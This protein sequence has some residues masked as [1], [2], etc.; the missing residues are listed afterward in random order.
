MNTPRADAGNGPVDAIELTD[1]K[2][3]RNVVLVS[4]DSLRADHCGFMGCEWDT[5]PSIDRLAENSIVF[6]N[7][8]TPGPRTPSSMPVAFTG[9]FNR[10][11]AFSWGEWDHRYARIS[12]H[13][14]RHQTIAERLRAVGYTTVGVTVN[15]WTH[16]TD[17]DIGFD[18][19][20]EITGDAVTA[21]GRLNAP[22]L[23][24]V[25]SILTRTRNAKNNQWRLTKDWLVQWTHYYETILEALEDITEPYF[26][27]T[28]ILDPHQPYLAPRRYRQET[29]FP[30]MYYANFREMTGN[31]SEGDLSPFLQTR[32][33]RSYR[34]AIRSTDGFIERLLGDLEG[35]PAVIIHS[36]HGD[37]LGEHGNWGHPSELYEENLH[38]PLLVY[39]GKRVGRVS[40]P[41]SLQSLPDLTLMIATHE[42]YAP[43]DITEPYVL[44]ATEG[45]EKRALRGRRWKLITDGETEAVF[46]LCND[47]T[48][49]ID[50]SADYPDI[51]ADLRRLLVHKW[52]HASEQVTVTEAA[53]KLG[54]QKVVSGEVRG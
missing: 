41:V 7:A 32:L 38:V 54:Q 33:K 8:I 22:L 12:A 51:T 42:R 49:S 19:F 16:N 44:V 13:L 17:F 20:I 36:D 1:T 48:E 37:A 15:P 45:I 23:T 5:T 6:E 3:L 50:R 46:D 30:E 10:P 53:E 2:P 31:Q 4:I 29:T 40:A 52:R 11:S 47:P 39:D 9:R 26:L 25:D 34:D 28:F 43:E 21:K 18:H 14:R 35:N 27:W 24:G